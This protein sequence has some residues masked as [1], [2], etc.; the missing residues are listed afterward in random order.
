MVHKIMIVF[1]IIILLFLTLFLFRSDDFRV[2]SSAY[3]MNTFIQ[4]RVYDDNAREI[5]NKSFDR[6][7]D[8]ENKMSVNIEQSYVYQINKNAGRE[9]VKVDDETFMLIKRA[10]DYAKL[11]EGKFDPSIG[12]LV[13]LWGIGS[14]NARIPSEIEIA[15]AINKVN[16]KWIELNEKENTVFLSREG[17]SIDLGGIAKGYAADIVKDI[18][19]EHQIDSAYIDIGGNIYVIGNRPDERPWNI[20]IQDPRHNRGNVMAGIEL[21]NKTIVTSGNYERYFV[22]DDILYHHIFDPVTG[23]PARSGNISTSIISDNSMDADALSTIIFMSSPEESMELV[24]SLEG[25]EAM[26]IREDLGI[27]LSSGLK[28]NIKIENTDFYFLD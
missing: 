2:T 4:M 17:M 22:E 6:I 24:E 14:A 25:T 19:E 11:S 27:I 5:I 23:Y 21:S 8:I 26:I 13:K 15:N 1:I 18:V 12:P 10:I 16:Y 3:I 28:D 7:R 20:G 9:A